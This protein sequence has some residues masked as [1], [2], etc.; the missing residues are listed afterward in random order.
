[1]DFQNSKL[2]QQVTQ[3]SD[4]FGGNYYPTNFME[5][6]LPRADEQKIELDFHDMERQIL[7]NRGCVKKVIKLM[8]YLSI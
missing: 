1:M 4:R 8:K 5:I 6:A 2:L 3:L 7:F